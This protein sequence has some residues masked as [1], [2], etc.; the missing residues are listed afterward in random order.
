MESVSNRAYLS[1]DEAA[2]YLGISKSLLYRMTSTQ[3]IKH[4]K[5]SPKLIRFK[6]TDLD[7]FMDTFTVEA[8]NL[9]TKI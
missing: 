8:I 3:S 9:Q 1:V 2:E 4:F 6:K 5:F 7:E